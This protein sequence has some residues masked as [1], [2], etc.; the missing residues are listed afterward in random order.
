MSSSS[1]FPAQ[2]DGLRKTGWAFVTRSPGSVS[3]FHVLGERASGTN[4]LRF[5]VAKNTTL[6]R[7]DLYG[8]KHGFPQF[9]NV[10]P[11]HVLLVSFRN[12]DSWLLSMYRK[13]W[14]VRR[15][16]LN[17]SFS[18]WLRQPYRTIIDMP[19]NMGNVIGQ[20]KARGLPVQFDRHPIDGSVI[21]N[22]I[23]LRNLK[24]RAF[25]GIA[26]RE[27]N[28]A[29]V[30]YEALS[31]Q[32]QAF[33]DAFV[34]A[35]GCNRADEL[36]LTDRTLGDMKRRIPGDRREKSPVISDEDRAFIARELD[37]E[38]EAILGYEA[39]PAARPRARAKA[40]A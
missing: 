26:N 3:G 30:R 16:D 9:Q 28:V 22:P 19:H 4:F 39:V 25:L 15:D 34:D 24:N 21:A 32:T 5:L 13:P 31:T 2:L 18:E 6:Q 11:N 14:H 40:R 10:L 23:Q 20:E 33:L 8:W 29:F 38:I 12:L 7:A 27:C 37:H 36:K 17:V 1:G 35:F